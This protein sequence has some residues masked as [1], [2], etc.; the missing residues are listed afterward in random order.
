MLSNHQVE[1]AR[2][3]I[4]KEYDKKAIVSTYKKSNNKTNGVTKFVETVSLTN[5]PCKLSFSNISQVNQTD[6]AAIVTQAV[7]MFTAPDVV[8]E[9]GSKVT[10]DNVEYKNSGKPAMYP[11]HQEIILELFKEWS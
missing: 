6:G 10:I 7:K 11:T 5:Q 9:T 1:L 3:A 2:K 4:E 8:I